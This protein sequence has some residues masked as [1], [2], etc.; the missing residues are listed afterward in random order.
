[1]TYFDE[2]AEIWKRFVPLK[3]QADTVQGELLRAVEKLRDEAIRN[4][5]GNW[6]DGFLI[7]LS[8]LR[9]HLLA[10]GVL[11]PPVAARTAEILSRLGNFESPVLEDEPYDELG[12]RVVDYYR[13]NGSQPHQFNPA[14][15][16]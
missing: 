14:L 9:L 6:D 3:G 8:Y 13:L 12:D 2:A 10:E 1:M 4:G 7:L 5:N 15:R 11:S 16:R